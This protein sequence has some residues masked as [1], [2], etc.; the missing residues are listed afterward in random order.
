MNE[1]NINRQKQ[2][3]LTIK[4]L[5]K[6]GEDFDLSLDDS[7]QKIDSLIEEVD[8]TRIKIVLLGSFSDGK[9]SAIAGLLG[10]VMDD[11]KI[12]IDES[13]DEIKVYNPIGLDNQYQIIDTPGLFGSKTK[14]IE[15]KNIKFSEITEKFISEAHILLYVCDAVNPFKESHTQT[16]DYILRKYKK[17]DSTVF[18]INKMDE[19]GVDLLDEDDYQTMCD[20][21]SKFLIDRLTDAIHLTKEEKS[22]IEVVCIAADPKGKGLKNWFKDKTS[23]LKRSHIHLLEESVKKI[24][25]RSD[26]QQLMNNSYI[27]ISNDIISRIHLEIELAEKPLLE[28]IDI[29]QENNKEIKQRRDELKYDLIKNRGKL[30]ERIELL[31]NDIF[32]KIDS[33]SLENINQV[34][35]RNIGIQNDNVTFFIFEGKINQ[36]LSENAEINNATIKIASDVINKNFVHHEEILEK[37]VNKGSSYLSNLEVTNKDVLKARDKYKKDKKFKPWGATKLADKIELG[38]KLTS[39]AIEGVCEFYNAYSKYKMENELKKIKHNLKN[40]I[41]N[42]WAELSETFNSDEKYQSNFAPS[43]IELNKIIKQREDEFEDLKRSLNNFDR[44]KEDLRTWLSY[45]DIE[46]VEFKEIIN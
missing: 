39:S 42:Y 43:F 5:L 38:A 25:S 22:K 19:T 33:S 4:N 9:T 2:Y 26:T 34:I 27:S 35:E 29:I 46:D 12:D 36:I 13:S 7:L 30:R 17:L 14:E 18:I 31:T 16:I 15:N 6:K 21:K 1:H 10:E 3:L 20:V 40:T 23:Y 24:I 32:S 8:Q 11:M 44:Y 41:N 28:N 45:K 37:L